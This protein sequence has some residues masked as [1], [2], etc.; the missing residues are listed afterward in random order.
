MVG[1][2]L[3]YHIDKKFIKRLRPLHGRPLCY[4]TKDTCL[5]D[6]LTINTLAL[7]IQ[8]PGLGQFGVSHVL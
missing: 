2:E 8:V 6:V 7:A 1:K 4:T 3:I 5:L